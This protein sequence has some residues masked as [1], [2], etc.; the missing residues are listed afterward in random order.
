M[1]G[2]QPHVRAPR[3]TFAHSLGLSF[4][5]VAALLYL[6]AGEPERA[7]AERESAW[8]GIREGDLVFQDLACGARCALIRQVTHSRYVHVGIV[9]VEDGERVVY[10]AYEPVGPT[11]LAEWVAR[12]VNRDLAVYRPD[13]A[14]LADL[15]AARRGIERM[16]GRPYDGDYQ[17]D[18]EAIYCS[19]LVIKAFAEARGQLFVTPHTVSLGDQ[20]ARVAAMSRGRLTEATLMVTPRDLA[21]SPRVHRVV[22]EL[23]RP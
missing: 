12:G 20:R 23:L 3:F 1:R 22:D 18:D 13:A 15:P 11:P 10:E 5:G 9:F 4:L 16:L 17:W 2:V 6:L 21:E 14:L 8:G 19:E 7:L